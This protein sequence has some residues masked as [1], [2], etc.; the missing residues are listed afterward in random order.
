[1]LARFVAVCVFVLISR[2]VLAQQTGEAEATTTER[3]NMVVLYTD[4]QAFLTTQVTGNAQVKTPNMDT[5]AAEGVLFTH[6]FNS[7]AICMGSRASLMTGMYEYKTGCNFSHGPM[8]PKTFAKSYPVLLRK[9]GYRTGFAGKFGFAVTD[10]NSESDRSYQ[11]LPVDQFDSWGGGTGQTNYKTAAN[12]YIAKY[13]DRYPHSSRAYGAFAQDF[14]QESVDDE[15]PF[16][17]TLF[18]K[19]PHRPFTPDPFFDSVYQ[20]VTFKRPANYGPN[21]G[22]HLAKQSRLGRQN[23]SFF[24]DM[25]FDPEHYQDTMRSYHQLIHGVD[26]AIGMLR[27]ELTKQ[28]L[29][30]NT[31][32]ILTSDNGFFC[33]SHGFGGKVLPYQEGSRVPLI[34]LDPRQ[35][36]SGKRYQHVTGTVDIAPTVL[37]Y[38]GVTAPKTMD[39]VSLVDVVCD[40]VSTVARQTIPLFQVW[41]SPLTYSMSVVDKRYKYIFWCCGEQLEPAEELFDL[42]SDPDEMVNLVDDDRHHAL[43]STMRQRYME[44]LKHWQENA[45]D[46]HNYQSFGK[47]LDPT[48]PWE[49]KSDLVSPG[50]WKSYLALVK[51]LGL[52]PED[53]FQYDKVLKAAHSR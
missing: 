11:V 2:C 31:I 44:Q 48:V 15:R 41:G 5:L 38:A 35:G 24:Y 50:Q 10:R 32:I 22:S 7:T 9:H 51:A 27:A 42:Q 19:A 8:R 3:P 49:K 4:D 21:Q 53:Y 20:D 34:I 18:F 6:H 12:K 25:G 52:K 28:G 43:L 16:C 30:D 47:L 36:A 13:A 14:I 17:L 23:L 46:Y 26:Y 29:A 39:G 45:V 40:P 1:M 33:G 37:E